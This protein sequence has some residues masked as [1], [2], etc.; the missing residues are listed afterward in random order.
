MLFQGRDMNKN[1][2]A[3]HG[4]GLTPLCREK[5]SRFEELLERFNSGITPH[6]NFKILFTLL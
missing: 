3:P 6:K 2:S 4:G 1:I 5:G